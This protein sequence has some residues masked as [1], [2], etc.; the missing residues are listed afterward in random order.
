M[1][2]L[3]CQITVSQDLFPYSITLM[4]NIRG[5]VFP[6]PFPPDSEIHLSS[7]RALLPHPI[8]A[9]VVAVTGTLS[10]LEDVR[11]APGD[12]SRSKVPCLSLRKEETTCKSLVVRSCQSCFKKVE[13]R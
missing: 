8:I 1:L 5:N 4:G 11:L 6:S 12:A 9:V 13:E 2:R 3:S 7:D 10:V